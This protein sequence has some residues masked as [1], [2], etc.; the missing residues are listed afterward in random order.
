[1]GPH[2]IVALFGHLEIP[3]LLSGSDFSV[4]R[5]MHSKKFFTNLLFATSPTAN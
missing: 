5:L 3:P 1:M 4:S 2:K